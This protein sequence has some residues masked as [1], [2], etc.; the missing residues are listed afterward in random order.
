VIRFAAV[1]DLSVGRNPAEV[2]RV[3][4]ASQTDELCS[5]NWNKGEQILRPV[6]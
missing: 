1:N 6:A 4:D 5:C 3:Q 2:L